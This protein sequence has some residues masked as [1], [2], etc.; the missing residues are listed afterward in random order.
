MSPSSCSLNCKT[1]NLV[2]HSVIFF[3]L[4]LHGKVQKVRTYKVPNPFLSNLVLPTEALRRLE[5]ILPG[6]SRQA[7]AG[8]A[9]SSTKY[10]NTNSL[11]KL[12]TL[13]LSHHQ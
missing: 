2:N 4:N 7:A 12:K 8:H 5:A 11:V 13:I 9:T 1:K 10:R 3:F 6:P